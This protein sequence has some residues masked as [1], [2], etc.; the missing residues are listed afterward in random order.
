MTPPDSGAAAASIEAPAPSP[1]SETAASTSSVSSA[2]RGTKQF[3]VAAL[4]VVILAAIL[5]AWLVL[6][7]DGGSSTASGATAAT[8]AQIT[9]LPARLGHPVFWLGPKEGTTYELTETSNGSVY[10]RYLPPGVEVGAKERY[11]TVATYPFPGAYAAL[12][13]VIKDT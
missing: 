3:R 8:G 10:I 11:Q 2:S 5:V 9:A 1:P 13:G 4:V 7:D 6:R 12:L